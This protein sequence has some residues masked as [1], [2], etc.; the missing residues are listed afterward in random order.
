[1]KEYVWLLEIVGFFLLLS[2]GWRLLWRLPLM[3]GLKGANKLGTAEGDQVV[4][5]E[6]NLAAMKEGIPTAIVMLVLGAILV[7]FF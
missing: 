5:N 1:M 7:Y 6:K 2:G 3:L 4:E